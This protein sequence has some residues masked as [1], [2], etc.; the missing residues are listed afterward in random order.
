[1]H[2]GREFLSGSAV[3]EAVFSINGRSIEIGKQSALCLGEMQVD[4]ARLA[5][6]GQKLPD[7]VHLG[8]RLVLRWK[9]SSGTSGCQGLRDDPSVV[10]SNSFF[11]ISKATLTRPRLLRS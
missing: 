3:L 7:V 11:G 10:A 4:G 8:A 2:Q 5:T 6:G 9:L 1:V